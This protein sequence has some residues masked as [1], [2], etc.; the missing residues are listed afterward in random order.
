MVLIINLHSVPHK[1]FSLSG[2]PTS[3]LANQVDSIKILNVVS[4]E[5][6]NII[7]PA[8]KNPIIEIEEEKC[9][10]DKRKNMRKIK[11]LKPNLP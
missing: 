11:F 10:N 8:V 6:I 2:R 7:D 3:L 1:L 5:R 9:L 4:Y